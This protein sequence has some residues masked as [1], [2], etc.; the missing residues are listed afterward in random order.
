VE[1]NVKGEAM[2]RPA[3]EPGHE[4]EMGGTGDGERLSE[5]LDDA[6]QQP[7]EGVHVKVRGQGSGIV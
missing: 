3:K 6:Q 7:V 1:G 4:D 2:I 5:A